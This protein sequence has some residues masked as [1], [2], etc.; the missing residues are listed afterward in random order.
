MGT[1][2]WGTSQNSIL[3]LKL[4]GSGFLMLFT[5]LRTPLLAPP[6]GLLGYG[7]PVSRWG[8]GK[9]RPLKQLQ[10]FLFVFSIQIHALDMVL[11]SINLFGK[12]EPSG[13][14]GQSSKWCR[15]KEKNVTSHKWE[16]GCLG[17]IE[18]SWKDSFVCFFPLKFFFKSML[19]NCPQRRHKAQ[20]K[21]LLSFAVTASPSTWL[22][23]VW[24][25]GL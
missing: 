13:L 18:S 14:I 24:C 4:W 17:L 8:R 16:G 20:L 23:R 5:F 1:S 2:G 19:S 12:T 25:C 11:K 15:K 3:S 22:H 6:R 7:P 10:F 9:K 21:L